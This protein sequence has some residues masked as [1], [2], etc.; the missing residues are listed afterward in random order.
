MGTEGTF[1]WSPL[2]S[3]TPAAC[4]S[5]LIIELH[6]LSAVLPFLEL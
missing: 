6:V 1:L 4:T 5:L 2:P 3:R